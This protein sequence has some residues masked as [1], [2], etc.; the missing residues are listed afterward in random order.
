MIIHVHVNSNNLNLY[1]TR[2]KPKGEIVQ[3]LIAIIMHLIASTEFRKMI[4]NI[5]TSKA[6]Q[7]WMNA[8]FII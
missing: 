5:D 2:N 1:I 3:Q 7:N 8:F 6:V 4:L